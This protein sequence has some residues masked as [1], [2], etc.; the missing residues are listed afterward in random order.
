[1][2]E[3]SMLEAAFPALASPLG[4]HHSSGGSVPPRTGNRHSGLSVTP[5]NVYPARD[6]WV[7]IICT[8]DEHWRNLCRAM[9]R[10][11]LLDDP[12]YGNHTQRSA[13]MD[14]VDAL[15]ASWSSGLSRN[16]VWSI[17]LDHHI[18]AAPV[19]D[20]TEVLADRHLRERDFLVDVDHPELGPVTLPRSPLRYAG[21]APRPLTPSPF[22]GEHTGEVLADWLGLGAA[23]V[24]GLRSRGAL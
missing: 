19:R 1:V 9:A 2:V 24:A 13:I 12:R 14:D 22:L 15:V 18:P 23:D 7:A 20:L 17:C 6:G 21:S 8:T 10:D 5:Y 16:A 11:D 3:V 4:M